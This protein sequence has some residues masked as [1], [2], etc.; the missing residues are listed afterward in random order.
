[1]GK[2]IPGREEEGEKKDGRLKKEEKREAGAGGGGKSAEKN[3]LSK[4]I[5]FDK[6]ILSS[7]NIG[8]NFRDRRAH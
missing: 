2:L 6:Y 5:A 7:A 4:N 1:M 3:C 8:H